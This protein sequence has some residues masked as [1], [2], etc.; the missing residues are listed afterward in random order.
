MNTNSNAAN[1]QL[2]TNFKSESQ[3]AF[4]VV[5]KHIIV[6]GLSGFETGTNGIKIKKRTRKKLL[7]LR[8]KIVIF[9][10]DGLFE[11]CHCK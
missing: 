10:I 5:L 11:K 9:R 1:H 7:I 2:I 6:S 3:R 4:S 8:I